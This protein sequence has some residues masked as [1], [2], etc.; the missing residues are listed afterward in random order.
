MKFHASSPYRGFTI[1]MYS[2]AGKQFEQVLSEGLPL[3]GTL[4]MKLR[5][6]NKWGTLDPMDLR[7]YIDIT[8]GR[9]K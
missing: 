8:R 5:A 1:Y 2:D 9:S 7:Y 6:L 4:L 3:D